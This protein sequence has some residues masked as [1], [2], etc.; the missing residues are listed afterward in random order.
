MQRKRSRRPSGLTLIELVVV[1]AIA[2]LLM[3]F[4]G[5]RFR[6]WIRVQRLK[7]VTSQLVSDLNF[8]RSEAASRSAPTYFTWVN[9]PGLGLSCYS[10]YLS[11]SLPCECQ[12]GPGN[13]CAAPATQ[14]EVR[15]VQLFNK[16]AVRLI[17]YVVPAA[18]L[19]A[20]PKATFGFDN[21]TGGVV[22][23]TTDFVPAAPQ[24]FGVDTTLIGEALIYRLRTVVGQGGQITVCSAGSKPIPGYPTC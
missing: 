15:T 19:P 6:E 2:T 4:A 13:A 12:L 22:F 18:G 10:I 5:V 9:A 3:S 14:T 23:G 1:V 24:A 20:T 7:A 21:L 8:A 16:D 11:R 17:S